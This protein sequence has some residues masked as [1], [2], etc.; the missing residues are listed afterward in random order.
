MCRQYSFYRFLFI[1]GVMSDISL[2]RSWRI[3]TAVILLFFTQCSN[4]CSVPYAF[5]CTTNCG[6]EDAETVSFVHDNAENE[7]DIRKEF[8]DSAATLKF[9]FVSSCCQEFE[10]EARCKG[11]SV[12]LSYEAISGDICDCICEYE[13]CFEFK[14]DSLHH[15]IFV[16]E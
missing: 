6:G 2:R 9:R 7:Y 14:G 15:K 4:S 16:F 5:Y 10:G 13:Y 1:L 8:F 12:F 3:F 11:D